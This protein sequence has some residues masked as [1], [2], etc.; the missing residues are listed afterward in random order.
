MLRPAPMAGDMVRSNRGARSF[1]FLT[2]PLT[3][4]ELQAPDV[5]KMLASIGDYRSVME[6]EVAAD[7]SPKE[8]TSVVMN[9]KWHTELDRD[10]GKIRLTVRDPRFGW[11]HYE[12]PNGEAQKL[13]DHLQSKAFATPQSDL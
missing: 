5:D 6:P 13:A 1:T 9:P 3:A 10:S 8:S 12:L 4:I 7:V 2:N 11:L